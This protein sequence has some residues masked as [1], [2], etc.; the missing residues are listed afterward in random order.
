MTPRRYWKVGTARSTPKGEVLPGTYE[1]T[2]WSWW[3]DFEGR[4]FSH[5]IENLITRLESKR[6]FLLALSTDATELSLILNLPG[7]ANVGDTIA[8]TELL[9][10]AQQNVALGIEVFLD[11]P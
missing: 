10:L 3:Q 5:E 6:A 8:P 9:R 2:C 4:L 1:D 11:C 7:D